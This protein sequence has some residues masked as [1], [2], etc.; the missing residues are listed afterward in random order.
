MEW[1]EAGLSKSD[2]PFAGNGTIMRNQN[3][4]CKRGKDP[5]GDAPGGFICLLLNTKRVSRPLP[6]NAVAGCFRA[7][8]G[9]FGML[10]RGVVRTF[11]H[12]IA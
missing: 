1:A 11:L 9:V 4:G 3:S 12:C 8:G 7:S 5:S 10:E 2:V 6:A